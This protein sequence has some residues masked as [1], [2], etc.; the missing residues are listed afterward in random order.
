VWIASAR[1]SRPACSVVISAA[2]LFRLDRLV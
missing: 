1:M 2:L